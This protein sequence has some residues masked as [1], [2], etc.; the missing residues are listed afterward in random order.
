MTAPITSPNPNPNPAPAIDTSAIERL[1]QRLGGGD[2]N[3]AV[4]ELVRE[5][6]GYRDRHRQDQEALSEVQKKL[7]GEGAVVLT[8]DDAKTWA[9]VS[10]RKLTAEQL[11]TQLKE[12]ETLSAQVAE[13][14]ANTQWAEAAQA[15]GWKPNVVQRIAKSEGLHL[16]FREVIQPTK[17]DPEKTETVRRAHVRPAADE[18]AECML[19][20]KYVEQH[21]ADFLPAL[22]ADA[23]TGG[24]GD[25]TNGN[26]QGVRYPQQPT[27]G[28]APKV[29]VVGK[30]LAGRYQRPSARRT[31]TS[32]G[33]D[34]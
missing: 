19:L 30:Q 16:E 12:R 4:A 28:K 20:D 13:H 6:Q 15:L 31:T 21:L 14:T 29:D 17:D 9:A 23:E 34:T 27:G 8:G 5:N 33:G 18:K 25:R 24:S 10:A 3:A 26:G 11:E 22:K 2:A 32:G 7:P 1:I